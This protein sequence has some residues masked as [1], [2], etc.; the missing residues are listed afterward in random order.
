M[1]TA[2]ITTAAIA[3][4][5]GI[6]MMILGWLHSRELWKELD[7]L[8][9]RLQREIDKDEEEDL[10]AKIKIQTDQLDKYIADA[11][12]ARDEKEGLDKTIKPPKPDVIDPYF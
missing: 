4:V 3:I 6:A 5:V 2:L 10:K 9:D 11:K 7:R 1:E 12:K 8:V